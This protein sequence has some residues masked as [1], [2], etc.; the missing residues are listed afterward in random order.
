MT[1][2]QPSRLLL[3]LL[4]LNVVRDGGVFSFI[5]PDRFGFNSQFVTLRRRMLEESEILSL[6]Y[7]APFPYVVADTLIFVVQ[8]GAPSKDHTVSISEYEKA[9]T[10]RPQSEF[11]K[12]A[13]HIFEYFEDLRWRD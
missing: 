13:N 12:N 6:L 3:D 11:R 9:A 7:R 10:S 8:K 2:A 1:G 5:V 4:V